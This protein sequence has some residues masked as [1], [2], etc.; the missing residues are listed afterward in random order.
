MKRAAIFNTLPSNPAM[1]H[2]EF[3]SDRLLLQHITSE[4]QPAIFKGLSHPE[5]IKYYGVHYDTLEETGIQ[6]Q[7]YQN[8]E[9]S[10]SGKWWI[11][12]LRSGS[13]FCG[14]IGFNDW[15]KEHEKAEIGLWLFPEF[16]GSGIM[17][18]A[19]ELVFPY[20]FD[21]LH[22]HR[23]EAFVEIENTNSAKLL[24]KLMFQQE[25]IMRDAEKK[26]G[27]FI[28]ITIWSLLNTKN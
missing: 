7:W 25:G 17:Q 3:E 9:K 16:W 15:N 22:I 2:P 18:E 26:N 11:I 19:A 10:G 8:L 1:K 4:D 23:L 27:R 13:H 24:E 5:I 21:Q 6:M 28:S 20:L 12:R 14:A